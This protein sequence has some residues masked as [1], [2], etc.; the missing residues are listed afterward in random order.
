MK[1]LLIAASIAVLTLAMSVPA[2]A[3]RD[4]HH[5]ASSHDYAHDRHHDRGKH[6]RKHHH[7]RHHK[8][9]RR[10]V[11]HHYYGRD[12]DRRSRHRDDRRH[13]SDIPLVT[14]DGYPVVRIQV[15][16]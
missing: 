1:R 8:A 2:M 5:G 13:S 4:R 3:D 12:Y 6:H 14:V 10:V 16:H 11:E 15:N 9:H 7:K